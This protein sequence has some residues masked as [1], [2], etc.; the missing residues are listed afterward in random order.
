MIINKNEGIFVSFEKY[1]L[2]YQSKP[3]NRK[4]VFSSLDF[5]FQKKLQILL[6]PSPSFYL[7]SLIF[8]FKLT[9]SHGQN[10]F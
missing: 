6:H 8:Q 9:E 2:I 10:S 7:Q 5:G 4:N 1:F 3:N